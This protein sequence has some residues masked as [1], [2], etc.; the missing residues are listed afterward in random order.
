MRWLLHWDSL[1]EDLLTVVRPKVK[2][3]QRHRLVGDVR[4]TLGRYRGHVSA[5]ADLTQPLIPF[6][7]A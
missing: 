5:P 2:T 6:S 4:S 3:I 1:R 7:I